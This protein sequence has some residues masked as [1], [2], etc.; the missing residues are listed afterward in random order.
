M[1]H[2]D[3]GTRSFFRA[4]TAKKPDPMIYN[5]AAERLGLPNG[6]CVVVEDSL[7]GLRAAKVKSE[8]ASTLGPSLFRLHSNSHTRAASQ[9]EWGPRALSM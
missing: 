6:Q 9:G 5:L 1:F 2:L 4:V 7:V 3:E 8:A